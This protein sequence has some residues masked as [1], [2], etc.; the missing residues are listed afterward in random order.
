MIGTLWYQ[1]NAIKKGRSRPAQVPASSVKKLR[2]P[3]YASSPTIIP[4][5]CRSDIAPVPE[6]VSRSM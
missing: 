1:L 2:D 3:A 4:A 6:S 5:H